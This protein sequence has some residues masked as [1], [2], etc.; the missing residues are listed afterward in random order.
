VNYYTAK[1]IAYIVV[2]LISLANTYGANDNKYLSPL[3]V[4]ASKEGKSL[5]IAEYTAKQVAVFDTEKNKVTDTI[6]IP[7]PPSGLALSDDWN[8]LYVT[9]ASPAGKVCIVNIKEKKV[10]ENLP[11]GHTPTA[12]VI[13]PDGRFL[14][15][16][17]RFDNNVSVIDLNTKKELTRIPVKREP[18]ASA[19]T[20]DGKFLFVANSLPYGSA[21]T[22]YI[23]AVVS[24]INTKTRK[25]AK[26]IKLPNGS[27]ELHDICISSDGKYAYVTHILARYQMPTTQLE[28]G[29]MNTNALSIINV[30]NKELLNTVLL[31]DIDLGAANPWDVTCTRDNKYICVAHAGSHEITLIDRQKMHEKLENAADGYEISKSLNDKLYADDVK[32]DLAF[33]ADLKQRIKLYGKGP[34]GIAAVGN[35]IYAAEYFSDSLALVDISNKNQPKVAS[36]KLGPELKL[37][38][39]RKGQLA[40]HD[41]SLCFQQWQSCSSCHPDARSDGLNWDLLNDG[42]GNPKSSKSLLLSH[43]TPPV[44]VTGVRDKAQT[45]V[46]SGIKY[47][48]FAQPAPDK[49]NEIDQYLESLKPV[50]SP[51]LVNGK[52]SENAKKGKILF[53]KANCASCH[54]APLYTNMQKYDVGTGKGLEKNQMFDTPTLVEI[55]RTA[56]YLYDGRANTIKQVLKE[57]NEKDK[58]GKTNDLTEKQIQQLGEFILSL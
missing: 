28:R 6:R 38:T 30:Q 20:T 29:W 17:N 18:L 10:T 25:I 3:Q 11:V 54:P 52:L 8:K 9:V 14:Y 24:V 12:P 51:Y 47:I 56:P 55:W 37:S 4:L 33:L 32:N 43:K 42:L 45:A 40:F 5:Y 15:V 1:T 13:S 34:R 57:Y 19:I 41:A 50:P 48:Q 23:S 27:T 2:G 21:N 53:E 22:N 31:D 58:H 16:S 39:I 35:K 49:A 46:R 44:M 7:G 26:N 36:I